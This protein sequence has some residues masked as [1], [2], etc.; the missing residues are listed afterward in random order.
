MAAYSLAKLNMPGS[1]FFTLYLL[2][3]SSLPLQMFLVPLFFMWNKLHLV[4][5][6]LGVGIIYVALEA[7][8]LFSFTLVHSSDPT[9]L[10]RCRPGGR[11]QR[12][13]GAHA[14]CQCICAWPAFLTTGLVTALSVWNEFTIATVFLTKPQLF[15]IV[16]SY[17]NFAT[18]FSRNWGLTSA[19]AVMMI[20]PLLIIF[21]WPSWAKSITTCT[22][23][24]TCP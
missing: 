10:R 2:T 24:A 11:R 5:T 15:T 18:R 3:V 19:G 13:A 16:T 21:L 9:R 12:V 6:L 17:Q 7:P 20:A 8:L 22:K 23:S 4:N 1:N 14:D